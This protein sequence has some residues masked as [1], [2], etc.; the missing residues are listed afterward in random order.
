MVTEYTLIFTLE[1]ALDIE[2]SI[3]IEFPTTINLPVS[4]STVVVRFEGANASYFLATTGTVDT[5]NIIEISNIFGLVKPPEEALTIQ[6]VIVGITNPSSS[7][8][9]G[10]FKI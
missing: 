3:R 7:R 4:G 1:H 2:A 5:G 8:P 9:A 6:V 10:G